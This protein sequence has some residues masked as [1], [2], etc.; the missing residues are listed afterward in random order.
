M[1]DNDSLGDRMKGYEKATD[2]TVMSG[3][4]LLAR[5]D[6]RAFHTFTRGLARPFDKR[7]TDL[8]V[9]TTKFLVDEFDAVLGYT[10]SDEISLMWFQANPLSE[11]PFGG[12]VLK[13]T[14]VLASAAAATFNCNL[15][16]FL[17]EKKTVKVPMFDCRVWSVPNKDEAA[18]YFLWRER[19]ATKNSI[20]MAAQSKFSHKQ[21]MNK[22]TSDMQEMLFQA[23]ANWN[24]YPAFFKRGTFVRRRSIQRPFTVEE[25]E[26]LPP[27][28][29]AKQNPNLVVTRHVVEALDL[30]PMGH[31]PDR[32]SFVFGDA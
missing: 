30:P 11:L 28:H 15:A 24:D 19:D 3:L 6:G 17:P 4:P 13:L 14:S 2:S 12:R 26:K 21:L 20:A 16:D 25:I 8:M 31:M 27:K 7:F 18:N 9:W 10:Q 32:V 23:G 5:I 22:N 29:E 1:S